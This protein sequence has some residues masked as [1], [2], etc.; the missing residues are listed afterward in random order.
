MNRTALQ[1]MYSRLKLKPLLNN[2]WE[3]LEDFT[4]YRGIKWSEDKITVPKGFKFDWDSNIRL[5]YIFGTPMNSD[6]LIGALLHD[7]LYKTKTKTRKQADE[8]FNEIMEVCDVF[9]LK[10]IMY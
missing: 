10:R 4:Y 3:L 6:T 7:Y 1:S 9:F 2:K 8:I 5:L